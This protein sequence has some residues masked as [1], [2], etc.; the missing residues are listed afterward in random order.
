MSG[1]SIATLSL[2]TI[3]LPSAESLSLTFLTATSSGSSYF[4]AVNSESV[5][6]DGS[7]N[8]F[9]F[10]MVIDPITRIPAIEV[11]IIGR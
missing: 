4:I 9:L 6:E 7:T 8:P 5:V 10:P 2:H 1:C 11:E 3:Q